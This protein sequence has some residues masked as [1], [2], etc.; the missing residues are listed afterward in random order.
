MR[1][2]LAW[3]TNTLATAILPAPPP[4][5]G[6]RGQGVNYAALTRATPVPTSNANGVLPGQL[7]LFTGEEVQLTNPT[8]IDNDPD[9]NEVAS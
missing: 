7:D 1:S 4:Q 3:L 6:C 9:G 2:P 5:Q 8:T